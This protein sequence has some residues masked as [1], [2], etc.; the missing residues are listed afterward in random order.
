LPLQSDSERTKAILLKEMESLKADLVHQNGLLS[1][2]EPGNTNLTFQPS[3]SQRI[4][5][6]VSSEVRILKTLHLFLQTD[7]QQHETTEV[8]LTQKVCDLSTTISTLQCRI[9][10]DE[11]E[12]EGLKREIYKIQ[13]ELS[14]LQK[15]TLLAETAEHSL[16]QARTGIL[17]LESTLEMLKQQRSAE[18]D[19][20][21]EKSISLKSTISQLREAQERTEKGPN[22]Q[23]DVFR[24]ERSSQRWWMSIWSSVPT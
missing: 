3:Q 1:G 2:R 13:I 23:L 4:L 9:R 16:K 8:D 18:S 5:R 6:S 10:S 7:L 24:S 15:A 21:A 12:K 17:G 20:A 14:S 22:S 11:S 19:R